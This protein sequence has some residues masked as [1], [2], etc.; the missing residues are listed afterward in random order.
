MSKNSDASTPALDRRVRRTRDRL[1]DA[2]MALVVEKPFDTITVQDVLDR[3]GVARSTFY[4][5]FR[6]TNDLFLSDSDD[7]LELM[8]TRLSR[9]GEASDRLVAVRELFAHVGES[10]ALYDALVAADRLQDFLDLARDHFARGIER[11]LAELPRARHL[12][13]ERRPALAQGLAGALLS[14]LTW[15]IARPDPAPP[16]EMDDLFHALAWSGVEGSRGA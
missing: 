3:A 15:W 16:E 9:A 8:A 2:L 5:H 4:N 1:G 7:F 13:G 12:P 14:L 11:R 6:D 10:R